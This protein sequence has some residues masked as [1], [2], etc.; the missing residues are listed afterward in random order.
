MCAD[1]RQ[2]VVAFEKL[3]RGLIAMQR[4]ESVAALYDRIAQLV[5]HVKKYE[6]PRT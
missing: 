3:A 1:N 6:Q 5:A 2:Q 4:P